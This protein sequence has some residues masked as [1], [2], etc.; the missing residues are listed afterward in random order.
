MDT[1]PSTDYLPPC[2]ACDRPEARRLDAA[3]EWAH[4]TYYICDL[5]S[6]VWTTDKESGHIVAHVTVLSEMRRSSN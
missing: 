3:S 5:C 2:P 6:H 1:Q 4:V